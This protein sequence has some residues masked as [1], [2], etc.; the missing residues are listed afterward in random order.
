MTRTRAPLPRRLAPWHWNWRWRITDNGWR[1]AM[2]E[3]S[4]PII[5]A[6][7]GLV[8]VVSLPTIAVQQFDANKSQNNHH[9]ATT[10]QQDLIISLQRQVLTKD[11][12]IRTAQMQN[13]GTLTEIAT[14]QKDLTEGVPLITGGQQSLLAALSWL[15]CSVTNGARSCGPPPSISTP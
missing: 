5:V 4:A 2:W 6:L 7:F 10:K 15:E 11:T 8:I 3:R 9:T 1:K 14:L 12:A 13:K